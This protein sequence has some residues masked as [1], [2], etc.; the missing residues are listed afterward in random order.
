MFRHSGPSG[1][2]HS[3]PWVEG[4]GLETEFSH[5]AGDSIH[6]VHNETP[7]RTLQPRPGGAPWLANTQVGREA[8]RPVSAGRDP[9]RPCAMCL[10]IPLVPTCVLYNETATRSIHRPELCE[11]SQQ[12]GGPVGGR[13]NTPICGQFI[14]VV[15]GLG[16]PELV[17]GMR[18]GSSLVGDRAFEPVGSGLTPGG[19]C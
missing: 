18:S 16:V 17:A 8:I 19:S 1:L 7:V 15:G 5:V 6:H 9:P 13:E 10:F 2:R 14:G 12:I 3:P 4:A 11:T